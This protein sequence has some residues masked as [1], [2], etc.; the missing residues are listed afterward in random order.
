MDGENIKR[1]E[2]KKLTLQI[3]FMPIMVL[4]VATAFL[5]FAGPI[6]IPIVLAA[7]LTYLLLPI[8]ERIKKLK[9]PHWL[10]VMIVM[11]VVVA[12]FALLFYYA[13]NAIAD[14][15]TSLPKYMNQIE[16]TLQN[17]NVKISDLI[18]RLPAFIKPSSDNLPID[19]G[20]VQSMG[21]FLLK[22]V[23][24][25]TSFIF[26][27]VVIFFLVLFMLLESELFSRKFRTMFGG[28]HAEETKNIINEIN[29]QIRGYIQVRFYIFVGLSIAITIGLLILDVQY[30]YIWGPLAGLLNIIP[31]IGAIFGAIPPIILAGIQ[32]NSIL[33]MVYVAAFFLILQTIEGNYI[34]PELTKTSVDL[35]AVTALISLLYWGWI[36]GGIG[37]FLAVPVTAAIK[38]ICDHIEPLKPIGIILGTERT[39]KEP[40]APA[41]EENP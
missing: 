10:A 2:S 18:E 6:L 28:A 23:H 7:A 33:Y 34:T 9:V 36:W 25:I 21:G 40:D 22:G 27:V 35:N 19:S 26:G 4:A 29:A 11:I 12:I 41:N 32:H 17:W 3:I 8:V 16:S 13:V 39:P 37:L 30:A 31:Y 15:A 1:T 14:L 5:Y 24:S 38:V 20:K